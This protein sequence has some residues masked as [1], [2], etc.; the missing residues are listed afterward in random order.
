MY[1]QKTI[2]KGMVLHKP[3]SS[4]FSKNTNHWLG[5][6]NPGKSYAAQWSKFQDA[7]V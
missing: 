4:T 2:V 7:Y 5:A 1:K 6:T 3:L